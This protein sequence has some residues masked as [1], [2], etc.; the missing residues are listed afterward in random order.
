MTTEEE[1]KQYLEDINSVGVYNTELESLKTKYGKTKIETYGNYMT[2]VNAVTKKYGRENLTSRSNKT[3][4]YQKMVK[5]VQN[6][7]GPE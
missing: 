5:D 3:Q 1:V 7:F 6:N 2:A 4:A